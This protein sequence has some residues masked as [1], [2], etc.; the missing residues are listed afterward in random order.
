[1]NKEY[2]R[3]C[4]IT[5]LAGCCS[6]QH[7]HTHSS[8]RLRREHSG[9]HDKPRGLWIEP[10]SH[11]KAVNLHSCYLWILIVML[12]HRGSLMAAVV[13]NHS[14]VNNIITRG[15]MS[16]DWS[17][18]KG[19]PFNICPCYISFFFSSPSSFPF[20]SPF[21]PLLP[22]C[23]VWCALLVLCLQVSYHLGE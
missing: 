4:L 14:L 7:T 16:L 17:Y 22:L 3:V 11:N 6:R 8:S 15:V 1:M 21:F 2:D 23:H 18:L 10:L 20:A 5:T 9:S 12:F 13:Q 19:S